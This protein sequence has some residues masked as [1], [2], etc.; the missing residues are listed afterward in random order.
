LLTEINNGLVIANVPP[1]YNNIVIGTILV[2][3]VAVDHLRRQRLYR[4]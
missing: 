3:A 1:Q 2:C 4:K